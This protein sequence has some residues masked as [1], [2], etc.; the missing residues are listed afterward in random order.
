MTGK[1][2]TYFLFLLL[3]GLFSIF[4]N[5]YFTMIFFVAVV[6]L[7]FLLL[8]TAWMSIKRLEVKVTADPAVTEKNKETEVRFEV[9]NDSGFPITRLEL[10]FTYCNE[11]SGLIKKDKVFLSV[12]KKNYTYTSF[13]LSS[14]H[15]GNIKI[16]VKRVRCYDLLGIFRITKKL[17]Q[18]ATISVMPVLHP[19]AGDLI[20]KTADMEMQEESIH[21]LDYKPGN[22]PSEIF[23]VREYKEGDRPNQIHWKLSRKNQRLIMKEFSQ[24]LRDRAI[25]YLSY[26]NNEK[27]E[28]LLQGTDCFIE[29]VLSV[30]EGILGKGHEHRMVWYDRNKSMYLEREITDADSGRAAQLALLSASFYGTELPEKDYEQMEEGG[31]VLFITNELLEEELIRWRKDKNRLLYVIYINDLQKAPIGTGMENFLAA[32][33]IPCYRIDSTKLEETI[34]KL[35]ITA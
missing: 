6:L 4:Y 14:E 12:D 16:A 22:D 34:L 1:R 31:N 27:G 8:F 9:I 28:K 3:I 5:V 7:P 20:K 18:W 13:R 33:L 15:C 11:I 17:N 30:S 19:I 35:G 2:I 32:S 24:P 25:L 23:G 21:Y 26:K 10:G 29:A